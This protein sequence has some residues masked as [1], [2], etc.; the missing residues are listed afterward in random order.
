[1]KRGRRF[2]A[3]VLAAF[4]TLGT[5]GFA[6]V[7][8]AAEIPVRETTVTEA[9]T[10]TILIGVEGMDYTS[11]QEELV[12]TIN[13]YRKEACDAGNVPD[14]RNPSRFLTSSDYVALIPGVNC[15]KV[16]GIRAAEAS[17]YLD[18]TRPNGSSCFTVGRYF[19]VTCAENLQWD[20]PNASSMAGWI[21]EKNDWINQ[22]DDEVTG[23][24]ESMIN[25]NYKYYGLATF[26][27]SNDVTSYGSYKV[28][29][30]CTAGEFSTSDTALTDF[31]EEKSEHVIQKMETKI[32]SVSAMNIVG[33]TLL[34]EGDSAKAQL[35][36]SV[37]FT[38]DD[39][40]S[41]A[42]NT[43]EHCPVYDGVTWTSATPSV[44]EVAEDGTLTAKSAG[45]AEL[46][47]SIGS[48]TSKKSVTRRFLVVPQ[49][50]T[51]T[52]IEEPD[53]V[54][55]ESRT[56]P[57]LS[58]TVRA[59]LSNGSGVDLDMTWDAYDSSLLHTEFTSR[60]FEVTGT[61]YGFDVVQK[62][63]VNAAEITDIYTSSSLLTTE[64][65]VLPNSVQVSVRLSIG[66]TYT[67]PAGWNSTYYVV[68]DKDTLNQYKNRL[69][70]DF[71]IEGYIKLNTDK[72]EEHFDVVQKLHVNPATV[73][74]VS[75][76]DA[77]VTT[78]SGTAPDYPKATV[79]WSNG[80]V[81]EEDV[82]WQDAEPSS[83]D[84]KYMAREG[85]SYTLTGSYEETTCSL[86]V[87]VTP[88]FPAEA[89]LAAAEQNKTVPSGTPAELAETATV[90]W[91]NGD[92][93]TESAVWDAQVEEDYSKIDGNTFTVFGTAEGLNVETVVTVL[94][95]TIKS[96]ETISTIETVQKKAPVLPE[97]VRV[98]WSNGDVTDKAV[99]WE[100]IPAS[101]YAVPDT[102][103]T[104][105]GSVKDFEERITTVTAVIHV[106]D[107]ELV[108]VAWKS[109]SPKTQTSYYTYK[110]EDL[111]G[112]LI[113]TYDNDD[114]EEVELTSAMITVFDA[115]SQE[116]T[117]QVTITY[118]D[119]GVSRSF[120]AAMKLV[121]RIGVR[122]TAEPDKLSYIEQQAFSAEG[123]AMVELLDNNTERNI[124]AEEM[125]NVICTGYNM[126]PSVYGEQ[127]VTATLGDF[128]DTF[129]ITVAE[130]SLV[131][132]RIVSQ[133]ANR[134]FVT[135]QPLD[136]TGLSVN[137]VYDNET[138]KKIRVTK[139]MLRED[140]T[141][142]QE[143][144]ES[145]DFGVEANTEEAGEHTIYVLYSEQREENERTYT[146]YSV[147]EF[148]VNV[149]PKEVHSIEFVTDPEKTEYPEG[150]VH[151]D[152]FG[153]LKIIAHCNNDYD[154]EVI[155]TEDMI[156]GFDLSR[157]GEQM[158]TV[159]YGGQEI[160][161]KAYVR[162]KVATQ[163]V[164]TAPLK[165]TYEPGE[166]LDLTGAKIIIT[167]DN[168]TTEEIPVTE[169]NE[170]IQVS[171]EGGGSADD[172]LALGAKKLVITY[173]GEALEMEGGQEVSITVEKK[174]FP[175]RNEWVKGVWYDGN[176]YADYPYT[177]SW[178]R[179]AKGWWFSDT[180]GWYPR[181]KWQK[182]D[183]VYYYFK[184]NGYMASEE[185]IGGYW[186]SKNGAWVYKAVGKWYRNSK[187]WWFQTSDGW[188]PKNQW[189]RI[190]NNWYY[191]DAHGFMVT[192]CYVG[193]YWIGA[194][195]VWR[196]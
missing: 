182:I 33:D 12:A 101:S 29:W 153:G 115:D 7:S 169:E 151:F 128:S 93:T 145:K 97:T 194:D 163:T 193:R 152:L 21:A 118:T 82:T 127:T 186:L 47:A 98:H 126:S 79:T 44:L 123:L 110:K 159:S 95:A 37:T 154:E 183:G 196:P 142:T 56:A 132:L 107:R 133:P 139:E 31:E 1:M 70:G 166:K 36:V 78:P 14:P 60:E 75:L 84:R 170:D 80:D 117:Q 11:A 190:N 68:W 90:R 184:S 192:N 121:K 10:D 150:D 89:T 161:F 148:T 30:A 143:A 41:A 114:Q 165:T 162:E 69:G 167:Y 17:V 3:C 83:G 77:E 164:A 120:T 96:V 62:V 64:S 63:H 181:N 103:F 4:M 100:T 130:K 111:T 6:P 54:Y 140:M 16:A 34:H 38:Y 39:D 5:P 59:I 129:T 74:A 155:V 86:K 185:W 156:S 61:I 104:V 67:Y 28:N 48:G 2:T 81:T 102:E 173:K 40:D 18:H 168:G 91:S 175:Y 188:Y 8:S 27:P 20:N 57:Q 131:G 171:F 177:G 138:E 53:M 87:N 119:A 105:S 189:Q 26:N 109:G 112:T 179:N 55:T 13:Q 35:Q 65:G 158:V 146:Y 50:V 66:M 19:G 52:G 116:S 195:G 85:G 106:N 147:T 113:A 99:E 136:V 176:G 144:I 160:T 137:A 45:E 23:H 108:S 124:S 76:E 149:I 51:V 178:K 71:D 187:G 32:S 125:Q 180:S 134:T 9:G 88:A 24:Y 135:T 42:D 191:F 141:L 43:T 92:T 46:T 157:I 122:I 15:Q 49:G 172:D 94:P 73:T 58:P 174:Q 22:N 72:G 25:P